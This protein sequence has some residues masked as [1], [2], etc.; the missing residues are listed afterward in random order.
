MVL[1][2]GPRNYLTL[3]G[4]EIHDV[5]IEKR[6]M[7]VQ[8]NC[9]PRCADHIIVCVDLQPSILTNPRVILISI[10]LKR[11]QVRTAFSLHPPLTPP[12]PPDSGNH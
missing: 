3:L 5:K 9:L 6:F 12:R 2:D 10:V 8:I 11:S 7:H 4:P 1:L